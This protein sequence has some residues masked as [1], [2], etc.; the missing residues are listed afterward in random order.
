MEISIVIPT[1]NEEMLLPDLLEDLKQQTFRDHEVIVADAGS[2]DR[3]REIAHEYGAIVVPGGLPAV[4]RNSGA[5]AAQGTFL[6]F[7]DADVRL[8]N[9]FLEDAHTEMEARYLD[10]A[11]CEIFPLSNHP[12]DGFLHDFANLII[13]LGQFTDPHAPGFCILISNRL[14]KRVNGFDETLKMAEDH[15]LVKRASQ[16]RS[17]RVLNSTTI[18]VS[19]RRL[20][21]EGRVRLI[22]KY[23]AVELHRVFRGEIKEEIFEYEFGSFTGAEQTLVDTK[24]QEGQE[25]IKRISK[26]YL[27]LLLRSGESLANIPAESLVSIKE[28]FERLKELVRSI[29][30]LRHK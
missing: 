10:L 30:A 12:A 24:L 1:L 28:Q 15:D 29:L 4:G 23:L 21:K 8:S 5:R 6:F 2:S 14:F 9:T 13:K 22:N 17:L 3:T 26:E 11:T 19:V 25:L 7:I 18:N 27:N 20:E 16:F